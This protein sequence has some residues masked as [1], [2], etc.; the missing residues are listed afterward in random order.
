MVDF[1]HGNSSKDYRR[2]TVVCADTCAQVAAGNTAIFGV[3]VESHLVEG[4]QDDGAGK[5]LTYGQ[6]IT[7]ACIG[8]DATETLLQDLSN[9]VE[10]RRALASSK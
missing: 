10:Q 2:Q 9:A 6:S 4:R 3:M 5:E 7:D 1:S 8:W